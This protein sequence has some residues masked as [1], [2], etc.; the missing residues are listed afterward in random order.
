MKKKIILLPILLALLMVPF[1]NAFGISSFY[2]YGNP[3]L[4]LAP[5]ETKD[6]NLFLQNMIGDQN[7]SV[8]VRFNSSIAKITDDSNVYFLPAQ[9]K[10]NKMNIRV[11]IP[12]DAKTGSDY[13]LTFYFAEVTSEQDGGTVSLGVEQTV[14]IPVVVMAKPVVPQPSKQLPIPMISWLVLILIVLAFV[15][16]NKKAETNQEPPVTTAT[17][18]EVKE[19]VKTEPQPLVDTKEKAAKKQ[20]K[21]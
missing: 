3:P 9:T 10:D 4:T 13:A 7:I 11:T 20:A 18:H 1:I 8:K 6:I 2:G 5:G 15:Y 14:T 12:S 16:M 17:A 21:K 19:A